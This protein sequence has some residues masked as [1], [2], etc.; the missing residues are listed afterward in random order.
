MSLRPRAPPKAMESVSSSYESSSQPLLFHFSA[1]QLRRAL[2]PAPTAP[3]TPTA[4]PPPNNPG[5]NEQPP[6]KLE[7]VDDLVVQRILSMPDLDCDS[8]VNA[9]TVFGRRQL[10][11]NDNFWRDM[12]DGKG[13]L[14]RP[15]FTVK[16]ERQVP[17]MG[18]WRRHFAKWCEFF[19]NE[20]AMTSKIPTRASKFWKNRLVFL[21]YLQKSPIQAG[22]LVEKMGIDV[23]RDY[24][25]GDYDIVLATVTKDGTLL[26]YASETLR[27]NRDI[28]LAAVE[29]NGLALQY[30][31]EVLKSDPEVRA[32]AGVA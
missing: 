11:S 4:V 16:E 17:Y 6:T 2:P 28:V 30:A 1:A 26:Q 27:A 20:T 29:Q 31:S 10:A 3:P 8:V 5:P 22:F 14:D 18:T 24:Y 12:C 13:W 21:A 7:D 23:F 15:P 19:T 25:G 9:L 32:A